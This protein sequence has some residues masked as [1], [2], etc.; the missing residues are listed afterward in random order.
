MSLCTDPVYA[1][2]SPKHVATHTVHQAPDT[3]LTLQRGVGETV[4]SDRS[5]AGA[6]Q[7]PGC[8]AVRAPCS[9]APSVPH[10]ASQPA[11]LE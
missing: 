8:P 5:L 10:G 7:G 2:H 9:S 6:L 11:N 4:V 3:C 1:H